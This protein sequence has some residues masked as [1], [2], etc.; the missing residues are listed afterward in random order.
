MIDDDEDAVLA[1]KML[2]KKYNYQGQYREKSGTRSR[3]LS[4][5]IYDVILLEH[6]L[7]QGHYL[8]QGGV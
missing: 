4:T 2:L 5:M 8:R 6:E 7:Q 1:A 3:S